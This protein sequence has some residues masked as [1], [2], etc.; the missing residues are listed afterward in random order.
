M[1][2]MTVPGGC[3]PAPQADALTPNRS[4]GGYKP[5]LVQAL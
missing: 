5:E 4:L 1:P 3:S 2:S